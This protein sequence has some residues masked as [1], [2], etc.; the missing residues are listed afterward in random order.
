M[1]DKNFEKTN[2]GGTKKY[3]D[4]FFAVGRR[5]AAIAR[6]RIY[7]KAP[8]NLKFKEYIVKKGDM[9]VN[10]KLISEYFSGVVS[11]SVYEKPFILTETLNK[12]CVTAK[13]EGGGMQSQMGAF[14]LGVSRAL[15][16]MDE[17]LKPILRKNNLLTRDQR[18][19]E[20]RKVGMG[21]KSRRKKQSPKR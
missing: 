5:R 16:A 12:Y 17:S 10:G 7:P 13:I 20:R 21:G 15:S 3:K 4:Y 19:R 6:V 11:K 2:V 8:D 1:V 9:V 14:I 18:V